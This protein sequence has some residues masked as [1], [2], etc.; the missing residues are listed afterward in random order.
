M[1]EARPGITVQDYLQHIN[2]Y[3]SVINSDEKI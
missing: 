2:H 1:I 3:L